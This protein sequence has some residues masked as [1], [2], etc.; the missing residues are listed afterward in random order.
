MPLRLGP[1]S[2]VSRM[3]QVFKAYDVRGTVP[4]QL[5]GDLCRAIGLP[6]YPKT[7]GQK[8]LHVPSARLFS[9]VLSV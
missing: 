9:S 5:D 3:N 4:D 1:V 6:A 7:T 8:G 2:A